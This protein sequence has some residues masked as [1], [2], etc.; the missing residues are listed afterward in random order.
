MTRTWL[1][2]SV[3]SVVTA[4]RAH[5]SSCSGDDSD[6][7]STDW[8]EPASEPTPSCVET[9]DVHGYRECTKFGAWASRSGIPALTLELGTAIRQF[10]SPLGGSRTGT[11]EHHGESFSYRV[12]DPRPP[13]E[14]RD[15]AVLGQLRI[16]MG[17]PRGF[18]LAA[19]LELGTLTSS[20]VS[21]E[22]TSSG[23][24]GTPELSPSGIF[25][26]GGAA[27]AGA[28]TNLGRLNLGIE[29]AGGARALAYTYDSTYYACETTTSITDVA[30]IVEGRVRAA[31]WATPFIS[32]GATAGKSLLDESWVG[33]VFVGGTTRAFGGL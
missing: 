29:A 4:Q 13:S 11:I 27:V 31:V 32:I 15:T 10:A 2:V 5:A 30:P 20:T 3:L 28:S 6:S 1:L 18:Y 17:L 8:S 33:G 19:E 25:V 21:A 24:L 26:L 12:V 23:L 9:S 22:M 16:G 14:M 7:S